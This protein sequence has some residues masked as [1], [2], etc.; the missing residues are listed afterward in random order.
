M[1]RSRVHPLM[2]RRTFG[3]ATAAYGAY[4]LARP[5]HLSRQGGLGDD[6]DRPDASVRA[7]SRVIGVRDLASGAYIAGSAG[8]TALVLR[9]LFDAGDAAVFGTQLPT[10]Q[11]RRKVAVIASAWGGLALLLLSRTRR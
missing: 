2:L 9:A 4:A 10:P 1:A 5:D 7:L 3:L 8:R 11:T 6:P